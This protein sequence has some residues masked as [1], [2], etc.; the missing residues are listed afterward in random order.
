MPIRIPRVT[1]PQ[2][3]AT[4]Q[5][6]Q[7][8][9]PVRVV[10]NPLLP[11]ARTVAASADLVAK[12]YQEDRDR[13]IQTKL[14]ELDIDRRTAD[15]ATLAEY[16]TLLGSA[17]VD[18]RQQAM[19]N[20]SANSKRVR[21]NIKDAAVADLWKPQDLALTLS[22]Q[23][24]LD[25]HYRRERTRWQ[26]DTNEARADL[27]VREFGNV[28]F[29][30]GYD[31][32]TGTLS[33]E[34]LRTRSA[35]RSSIDE[36]GNLLGWSPEQ[37]R[38][39][40]QK[41]DDSAHGDLV[42]ALVRQDRF[43]EALAVAD[44]HGK[45]IDPRRREYLKAL[46]KQGKQEL[47]NLQR[48]SAMKDR[49]AKRALDLIHQARTFAIE[50]EPA[51]G[52][53]SAVSPEGDVTEVEAKAATLARH[54]QGPTLFAEAVLDQELQA[55]RI[56][57]EE[58]DMTLSY[59][60]RRMTSEDKRRDDG[61]KEIVTAAEAFLDQNPT[62]ILEDSKELYKTVKARGLL[63]RLRE[64][65]R[66]GRFHTDAKAYVYSTALTDAQLRSK[67]WAAWW[68]EYRPTL[69]NHE[70]GILESRW[71]NAMGEG[72]HTDEFRV[73]A[74]DRLEAAARRL[75]IIPEDKSDTRGRGE[76]QA[77]FEAFQTR[78]WN[79]IKNW[80]AAHKGEQPND[81]TLDVLFDRFQNDY[82]EV[83]TGTTW[84]GDPK[85][86]RVK[87]ASVPNDVEWT[88]VY[89][90]N[91]YSSTMIPEKN[92]VE[93]EQKVIAAMAAKGFPNYVPSAYDIIEAWVVGGSP[94]RQAGN[95]NA[96]LNSALGR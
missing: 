80:P 92:R 81:E 32:A 79:A 11:A 12:L 31:G 10:N 40:T 65:E 88:V 15:N 14:V 70:L 9:V 41:A 58:R 43:D 95:L 26:A 33:D 93:A 18:A 89:N 91:R 51:Q 94:G 52:A 62:L 46:A 48:V 55:G 74:Q 42:E 57:A 5:Q 68:L 17:A 67:S 23:Q 3:P 59:I 84:A 19:A 49:S 66:T 35:Y 6:A 13:E 71:K 27:L 54:P 4:A 76:A 8:V 29:G 24:Q 20:L 1:F 22:S 75:G 90:G 38:K 16:G 7:T 63:G 72:N 53:Y 96:V 37:K 2:E 47:T 36:L 83:Q 78:V 69:G 45:L 60:D 73:K 34:A 77:A 87:L 21:E 30:D 64:F 25:Q 82:V 85:F 50:T 28:A 86:E 44:A 56:S 39:A 61:D